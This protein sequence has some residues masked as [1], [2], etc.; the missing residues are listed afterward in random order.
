VFKIGKDDSAGVRDKW[1]VLGDNPGGGIDKMG[2][3]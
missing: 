2:K 1:R 3:P